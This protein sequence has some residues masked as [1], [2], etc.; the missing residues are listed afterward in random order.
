MSVT[1][2]MTLLTRD[3]DATLAAQVEIEPKFNSLYAHEMNGMPCL[4]NIGNTTTV[5]KGGPG[6]TCAILAHF[7]GSIDDILSD[8][9]ATAAV[10]QPCCCVLRF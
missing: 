7:V 6:E 4:S 1:I 5:Q 2:E 8:R 9:H 10:H 3:A